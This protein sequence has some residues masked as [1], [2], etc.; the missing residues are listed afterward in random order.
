M[1][2]EREGAQEGADRPRT[3]RGRRIREEDK[4]NTEIEEEEKK[5][6]NKETKETPEK[7]KRETSSKKEVKKSASSFNFEAHGLE[8]DFLEKNNIDP[9]FFNELDDEL[10]LEIISE[11]TSKGTPSRPNPVTTAPAQ[12]SRN[13][14][15]SIAKEFLNALNSTIA[16]IGGGNQRRMIDLSNNN[17]TGTN[18]NNPVSLNDVSNAVQNILRNTNTTSDTNATNPTNTQPTNQPASQNAPETQPNQTTPARNN[19]NNELMNTALDNAAFI[20]SLTPDLREEVLLTADTAFLASLPPEIIREAEALQERRSLNLTH[21]VDSDQTSLQMKKL[22]IPMNYSL[23][24]E[25]KIPRSQRSRR[26]SLEKHWLRIKLLE[27]SYILL[28]RKLLKLS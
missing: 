25:V 1:N 19:T 22:L 11:Y 15:N 4:Q 27:A 16:N 23:D 20:A 24:Q 9:E 26:I 21:L 2:P 17:A 18:D 8:S 13:D 28:M 6:D 14:N 3:G 12:T 5:E 7:S 10:K